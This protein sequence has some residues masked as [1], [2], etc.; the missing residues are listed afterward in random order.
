VLFFQLPV[1]TLWTLAFSLMHLSN[2]SYT[3][4]LPFG[5]FRYFSVIYPGSLFQPWKLTKTP[6]RMEL[7]FK[8]I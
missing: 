3:S 2:V 4:V 6:W 1:V 8:A 7:F 5:F